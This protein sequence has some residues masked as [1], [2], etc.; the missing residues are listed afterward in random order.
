MPIAVV[1]HG[2]LAT[3]GTTR[4]YAKWFAERGF[5]SYCFDFVGGGVGC[6][7][8]GKLQ[9]M[10]VITEKPDL[11]SVIDYVSSLPYTNSEDL[12]L[13]GCSQGGFVSAMVAS[14]LKEKVS[15]LILFYPALCIPDDARAG[16]MMFFKFD[17]NNIPDKLGAG[18]LALSG[19][20]AR[21]VVNMDP[22]EEI[23]GYKG[24]VL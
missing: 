4:H 13:M 18:P 8:D 23:K 12:T 14:E 10:T 16:K 2:F 24:S 3:Y 7:S 5:A 1:S 22:Y 15:R 6:H 11:R 20:Y 17:P 19:D 21:A 9:D